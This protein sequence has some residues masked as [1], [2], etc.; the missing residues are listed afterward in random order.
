MSRGYIE[1]CPLPT[2]PL[3]LS[4]GGLGVHV[5]CLGGTQDSRPPPYAPGHSWNGKF[6]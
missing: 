1:G 5:T 4:M 3:G 6:F 2:T